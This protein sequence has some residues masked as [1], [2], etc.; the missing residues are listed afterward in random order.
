MVDTGYAES[1][2][3]NIN[4][5]GPLDDIIFECSFPNELE[6]I[7]HQSCHLTPQLC[8]Q[9]LE[10]LHEQPRRVW[11]NH[12]KPDEADAVHKQLREVQPPQG[13]QVLL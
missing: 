9:L 11:I 8:L 4:A 12:L 13:W 6:A 1:V 10:G 2:I 3:E 7:A 5:L